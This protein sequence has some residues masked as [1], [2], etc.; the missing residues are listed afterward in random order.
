MTVPESALELSRYINLKLAALGQPT[1]G[2]TIDARFLETAGPLLRNFYQKDRLLGSYLCPAD[3]RIQSFL[4]EYVRAVS[5]NGAPRLPANTFVLD[6]AGLARVM[7]LPP[8][9]PTFSSPR[10]KSYRL[11]QGILHNPS[12]DRRTTQG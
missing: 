7:S 11:P 12:S 1:A 5:P 3:A 10:L 6:R 2:S 4:D 9:L 8:D